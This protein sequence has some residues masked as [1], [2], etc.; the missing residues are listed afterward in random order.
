M[1]PDQLLRDLAWAVNSPSL[2]RDELAQPHTRS[3][4]LDPAT[5]DVEHLHESFADH[6]ER[7]VGRYFERLVVYWLRHV[8]GLEIIA[9]T[10]P[11]REGGRTLGEIDLVFRDELGRVTHWELAVKFYLD[12]SKDDS[13]SDGAGIRLIGP[14][15]R[16]SFEEKM[17]RMYGHQ[18]RLSEQHFPDV[19]ARSAFVKGRIFYRDPDAPF[20]NPPERLSPQHLRGSWLHASDI[21]LIPRDPAG[22]RALPKPFWLSPETSELADTSI[23]GRSELIETLG[24]HFEQQDRPVLVSQLVASGEGLTESRRFFVVSD[25]WLSR[26]P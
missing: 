25:A 9:Q 4:R 16:D 18:L 5:V 21:E 19:E 10:F 15:A 13:Q 3:Y 7:R 11:V 20:D 14:N 12:A 23:L 2:I 26:L 22:F 8:R 17:N 1:N 24:K 6:C